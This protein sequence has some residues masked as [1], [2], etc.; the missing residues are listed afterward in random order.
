MQLLW[1]IQHQSYQDRGD[2]LLHVESVKG[3]CFGFLQFLL[4]S[5][6]IYSCNQ[7]LCS[8]AVI[9]VLKSVH[10][11]FIFLHILFFAPLLLGWQHKVRPIGVVYFWYSRHCFYVRDEAKRLGLSV[12]RHQNHH[13]PSS[14]LRMSEN[15]V[16][17]HPSS[18]SL[19]LVPLSVAR[20]LW[21]L[22]NWLLFCFPVTGLSFTLKLKVAEFVMRIWI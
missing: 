3:F 13:E 16:F 1:F 11:K 18:W 20:R 7:L 21:L 17:W 6:Y 14:M 2:H 5:L 22:S 10:I 9:L 15:P 12:M 4:S 19:F 8:S